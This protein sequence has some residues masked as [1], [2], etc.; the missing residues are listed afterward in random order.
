MFGS[1]SPIVSL[2]VFVADTTGLF[3]H[4]L[5]HAVDMRGDGG[6]AIAIL[7]RA[8]RHRPQYP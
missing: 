8:P 7:L 2:Q 6:A 1:Q 4:R 5:D 3:G